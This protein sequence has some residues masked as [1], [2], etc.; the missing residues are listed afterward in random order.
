MIA[1]APKKVCSIVDTSEVV[2]RHLPSVCAADPRMMSDVG[3]RRWW[4][5]PS[6]GSWKPVTDFCWGSMLRRSEPGPRDGRRCTV[7]DTFHPKHAQ[8]VGADRGY[9]A[10]SFLAA[11]VGD[12]SRP[13]WPPR[14]T[15]Q[16]PIYQRVRRLGCRVG[17]QLSQ[18]AR[19]KM[20]KFWGEAKCRH[21]A[22]NTVVCCP[23]VTRRIRWAGC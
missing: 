7:H 10:K 22:F 6:M 23:S 21:A 1:C 8:T 17:Y 9:F 11:L 16:E 13:I 15:S 12:A 4:A 2:E 18:R 20:E 5:P 3:P 19:K 14:A